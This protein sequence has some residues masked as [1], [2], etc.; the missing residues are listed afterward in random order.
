MEGEGFVYHASVF[1]LAAIFYCKRAVLTE[2]RF[3]VLP[4]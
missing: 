1:V 3:E 4:A 2:K